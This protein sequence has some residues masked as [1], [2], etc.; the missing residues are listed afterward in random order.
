MRI[1]R[2]ERMKE[3]PRQTLEQADHAGS[4]GIAR[5]PST[6]SGNGCVQRTALSGSGA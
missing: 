5:R 3:G 2:I 1:F 4:S 6:A